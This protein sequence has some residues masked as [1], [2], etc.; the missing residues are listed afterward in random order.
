MTTFAI[1]AATVTRI[2]ETYEPNFEAA[3]FFPDWRSEV[4]E[5][6][7]DW[8]LPHHYDALSGF[9]TFSVHSWLVRVGGRT[10]LIDTCVGN[11]KARPTMPS[12]HQMQ[13][14]LDRLAE[15]GVRPDHIDMVMCTHLHVD[16]VGWNTRLDDGH[17]V[18]TFPNARYLFSKL[19]YDFYRTLE[20]E[21]APGTVAAFHAVC[22]R[23]LRPACA[24]GLRYPSGGRAYLRGTGPWAY[25]GDCRHQA[26]FARRSRS[27]LRRHS[28]PRHSGL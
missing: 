23:S 14:L 10:I 8:M 22:G 6:H 13:T 11:G 3:T 25:P 7:R 1:G 19:D 20:P 12:W 5:Q 9:L 15:A 26:P 18:P 4:V 28:P 24:D 2:E 21:K 17:W 27:L 16:H